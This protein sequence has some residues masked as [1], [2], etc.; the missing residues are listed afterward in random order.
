MPESSSF[1][2]RRGSFS[3]QE[4]ADFTLKFRRASD[5]LWK[6]VREEEGLNDGIIILSTSHA[7]PSDDSRPCIPDLDTEWN[8]S[9]HISQ[10]PGTQ[11]WS[12]SCSL[13]ASVGKN[14][15]F[16]DITIGPPWGSFMRWFALVRHRAAWLGPRQ[17][18]SRFFPDQDAILGCFLSHN[19]NTMAILAVSGVGNVTTT[20]R[21]NGHGV[22]AVHARND[23]APSETTVVLIS[24]GI[25][26]D[27]AVASVM[28]HARTMVSETD[29]VSQNRT[30]SRPKWDAKA[31]TG[32]EQEWQDECVLPRAVE[33]LARNKIQI[34]NLII[35]DNWQSLDRT[36]S[37]QSQCGWSEFE[38][39]R[40]AFPSGLR[41]VVAQIRNLHP[42]LQNITVWHALLGYWGGISPDG[43]IAKTY[44]IIKVAQEGENS[45]PLTVFL[46]AVPNWDMFQTLQSYSEFHA[47]ARCQMTV[48]TPLGQ[49]V[50]LRSSVLGKSIC[51]YA[52]YEDD[53]LLKIGSYNGASQTGTGILGLFNVSTRHLTQ[54]ILLELFIGV[55]QGGKYAVRS[56]TTGQTSTPM[57]IG[58][59]DSVIAA[60][61]NEA[62]YG[63]LCAFPVAQFESD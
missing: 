12:L 54:V 28:Y 58:A 13:P 17:G 48:A 8:V 3:L 2:Y 18:G 33:E 4:S 25:D 40:K 38:A 6:R 39:D 10:S 43:L 47:A 63:I 44:N 26:F 5:K 52:G 11:L 42:A 23:S 37:D 56:H 31:I 57:S 9:S 45:H 15:T 7:L 1:L 14:S 49:T 29:A 41:S 36:G 35:D 61:I 59:P 32:W 24:E 21:D 16:R 51:A 30:N 53:L 27:H 50:I 55:F 62:G 60:S 46:N 20:I 34:T 19:G 22:V